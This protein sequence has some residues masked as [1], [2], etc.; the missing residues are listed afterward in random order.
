MFMTRIDYCNLKN[1]LED[2]YLDFSLEL[3]GNN[4]TLKNSKGVLLKE[5]P[6]EKIKEYM[7]KNLYFHPI[8]IFYNKNDVFSYFFSRIVTFFA[9]FF[10]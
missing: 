9:Y 4:C 8:F 7:E 1:F 5:V 3:I 6:L 10:N 2:Y